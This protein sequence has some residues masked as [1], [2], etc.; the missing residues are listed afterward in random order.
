MSLINFD[1]MWLFLDK[2]TQNPFHK[3]SKFRSK[4]VWPW[5]ATV[6]RCTAIVKMYVSYTL[7]NAKC[8]DAV[9]ENKHEYLQ[10]FNLWNILVIRCLIKLTFFVQMDCLMYVDRIRIELPIL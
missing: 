3:I 6:T 4:W 5:N 1:I 8:F 2:G 10:C 9:R 7:F